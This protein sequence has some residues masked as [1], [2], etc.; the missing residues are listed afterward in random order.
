MG[1]LV[2]PV[3]EHYSISVKRDGQPTA[4]REM[5]LPGQ[6]IA[7]F[8]VVVDATAEIEASYR[9]DRAAGTWLTR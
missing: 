9:D 5:N 4:V 1:S 2:L 7:A 6:R 8:D 3:A